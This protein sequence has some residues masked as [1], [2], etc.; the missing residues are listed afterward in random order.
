MNSQPITENTQVAL[1]PAENIINKLTQ[2]PKF[3]DFSSMFQSTAQRDKF[4]RSFRLLTATNPE[5]L[6]TDQKSLFQSLYKAAHDGLIVDGVKATLT[7]FNIREGSEW[8]KKAQYIPMV[9]GVRDKVYEFTGWIITAN[10]VYDN[11]LFEYEEGDTSKLKHVPNL[12]GELGKP[13][14]AYA[15][16]R[17]INGEVMGRTIMRIAEINAIRDKSKSRNKE[18]K[19]VGPWVDNYGEMTKKTVIKRLAKELPLPEKVEEIIARD[20]DFYDISSSTAVKE[21]VPMN[22]IKNVL[23]APV[24]SSEPEK[25]EDKEPDVS[26]KIIAQAEELFSK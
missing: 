17:T 16:A 25:I 11:E 1:N 7:I 12:L 5:L 21:P 19:L 2:D 18:G 14:G 4:V 26:P 24:I 6:N 10:I 8:I 15:I 3:S 13:I 23:V 22:P 20:N 9:K